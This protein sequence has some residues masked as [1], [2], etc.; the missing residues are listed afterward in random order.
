MFLSVEN[1]QEVI[2]QQDFL[3]SLAAYMSLLTDLTACSRLPL[4][5]VSRQPLAGF[6]LKHPCVS[7]ISL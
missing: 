4:I 7:M 5:S 1:Q 6:L 2:L 3:V